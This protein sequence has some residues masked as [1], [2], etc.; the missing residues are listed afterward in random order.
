[1][2]R[3]RKERKQK[4]MSGFFFVSLHYTEIQ[5]FLKFIDKNFHLFF[6]ML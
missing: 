3:R 4:R 1:M 6:Y 2:K 5:I